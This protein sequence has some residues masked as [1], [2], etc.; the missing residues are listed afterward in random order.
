MPR[1]HVNS[2]GAVRATLENGRQ[3]YLDT[4]MILENIKKAELS[5]NH[6]D[7]GLD[8]GFS[9][10]NLVVV[11]PD[12]HVLLETRIG[13]FD[14]AS[15]Q[16]LTNEHLLQL[17]AHHLVPFKA[18]PLHCFGHIGT[19]QGVIYQ[20]KRTVSHITCHAPKRFQRIGFLT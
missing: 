20:L 8:K 13:H 14:R 11:D 6:L 16:Y 4:S 18:Y 1:T 15:E 12:G 3:S 5:M 10:T 9:K 7:V 19:T 2:H 17:I